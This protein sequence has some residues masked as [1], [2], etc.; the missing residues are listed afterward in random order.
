[1]AESATTTRSLP[2]A[3]TRSKRT[4]V[5]SDG[6]GSDFASVE[7]GVAAA[8]LGRGAASDAVSATSLGESV[9]RRVVPSARTR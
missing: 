4:S 7:A 6:A 9:T 1:M 8:G 5:T 3:A 2:V